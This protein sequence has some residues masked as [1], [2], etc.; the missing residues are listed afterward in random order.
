MPRSGILLASVEHGE[1]VDRFRADAINEDI[2]RMN[3]DLV[4]LENATRPINIGIKRQTLRSLF[5][6]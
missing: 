5:E 3:N 4:R 1:N 6:Q 2:V